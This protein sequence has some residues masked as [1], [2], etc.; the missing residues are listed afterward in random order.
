MTFELVNNGGHSLYLVF[1]TTHPKGLIK[2]KE[3][4]WEVDPVT[5]VQYRDP[6]DPQQQLLDIEFEPAT[7]PLRRELL[8]HLGSLPEHK[9]SVSDLRRYALYNTVYKESQV[10]PVLDALATRGLVAGDGAD[11]TVRLGGTVELVNP[12]PG[13]PVEQHGRRS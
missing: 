12:D 10:K 7:E 1:A 11:G 3:A 2:M 8:Q 9:A 6:A 4:M 5:G 13:A